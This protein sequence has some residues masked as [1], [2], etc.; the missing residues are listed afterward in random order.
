MNKNDTSLICGEFP[1]VWKQLSFLYKK[2]SR[3]NIYCE[4]RLTNTVPIYD[5]F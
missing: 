3:S 5:K 2:I 4:F 1:N